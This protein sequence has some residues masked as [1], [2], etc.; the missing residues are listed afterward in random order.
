MEVLLIGLRAEV[1]DRRMTATPIVERL[2][3]EEH[4]HLRLVARVWYTQ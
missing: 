4:V 3:A 1:V 2:D